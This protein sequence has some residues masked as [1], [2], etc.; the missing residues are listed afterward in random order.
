MS[1]P[2]LIGMIHL[3]PLPGSPR[4]GGS[5]TAIIER[6]T[7]DARTLDE[8]GFD[9]VMIENFGDSPFFPDRVPP[10]TTASMTRVVGEVAAV[11]DLPIGVNVLRNDA[12]AALA[13]AAATGAT[14][15][16]VNVLS[17]VMF[18]DQGVVTGRAAEL[19]RLRR[20]IAPGVSV[21]ADVFVKHATPPAGLTIEQATI[22]LW[23]RAGADGII[24][25]GPGT[26]RPVSTAE[27]SSVKR[28]APDAPILIGSG[29]DE[30]NISGLLSV[31]SGVIVGSSLKRG[32][33]VHAPVDAA[34][35]AGFVSAARR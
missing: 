6:A 13:V 32:G 28:A 29:S 24:V 27:L 18:T 14:M 21:L 17:G 5:I 30:S 3:D 1:L 23:E 31:A 35:A 7:V 16:R 9:A 15:I 11:T 25:S 22:D 2:R 33:D 26:G 12:E 34:L 20:E 10:V 8:A 4:F 19:A